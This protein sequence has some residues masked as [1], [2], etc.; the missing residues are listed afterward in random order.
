MST[1]LR[2]SAQR[3]LGNQRVRTDGTRVNLVVHQVR[4]LQ[5]V[6]VADRD[7]LFELV[8]GHAVM[9]RCLA[10]SRQTGALE[11]AIL[12]IVITYLPHGIVD[13]FLIARRR[14]M[15]AAARTQDLNEAANGR[16]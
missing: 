6:D 2:F 1:E 5:H 16:A 11:Q 9:Q 4:Q 15:T 7:R 8:A 13:T 10:R 14:R 12:M 3:L